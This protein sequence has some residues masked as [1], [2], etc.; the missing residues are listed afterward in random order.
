[1]ALPEFEE[2]LDLPASAGQNQGVFRG[3]LGTGDVGDQDCPIS[4]RQAGL[5]GGPAVSLGLSLQLA[6]AG[7]PDLVG[8]TD[9]QQAGWQPLTGAEGDGLIDAPARGR[10]VLLQP[11][12]QI[13][14][15]AGRVPDRRLGLQPTQRW[16]RDPPP[17]PPVETDMASGRR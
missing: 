7:C 13:E 8:N 5:A 11:A 9:G 2:E 16:Q 12:G 1:M 3:H 4:A 10:G 6:S 17:Q 15:L 14:S